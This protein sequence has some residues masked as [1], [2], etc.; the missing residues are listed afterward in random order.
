MRHTFCSRLAMADVPM[1]TIQALA[2][3]ESIET[4]R[5]SATCTSRKRRRWTPSGAST[6]ARGETWGRR[7]GRRPET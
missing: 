2:G 5:P 6:R 1:L 4:R 3:H 7:R